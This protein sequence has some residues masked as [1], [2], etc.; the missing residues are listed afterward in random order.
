[1]AKLQGRITVGGTDPALDAVVEIHNAQGD[2][3]DQVQVDG[4][5]RY[6]YHLSAGTWA[7]NVWDP[8]GHRG[9]RAVAVGSDDCIVDI[10]LVG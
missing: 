10:E 3:V 9:T 2:F 7:L 5:G 4:D 1:M 8:H 6:G